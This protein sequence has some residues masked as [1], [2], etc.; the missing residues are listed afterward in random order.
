[1]QK[2]FAIVVRVFDGE[3]P[4]FQ[5]FIDHH[6]SIGVDQF[7]VVLSPGASPLCREILAKN[8]IGFYEAEGQ[9]VGSVWREVKE[10]YVAVVDADEYLHPDLIRFASKEDF[11]SMQMPW[12]MT[13][14]LDDKG[15]LKRR[16]P[17]FVFPQVKSIMR[18]RNLTGLG[19]HVSGTRGDGEKLGLEDGLQFPVHHYYLRGLDDLLLKEGGVVSLTRARS[20]G[21]KPVSL[22]GALGADVSQFPSRHAK[23]AF[24]LNMLK[25]SP[26]VRDPYQLKIDHDML[27]RLHGSAEI[28]L[29]QAKES[30]RQ[31]VESIQQVFSEKTIK[32]QYRNI[33]QMLSEQPRKVSFQKKVLRV[34]RKDFARRQLG[35]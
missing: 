5:S 27:M 12:R 4:Y 30:L 32:R 20:M 29:R 9:R 3:A 15:F 10:D 23:V 17:F 22:S 34:L 1:M 28:D 8:K 7:Y 6:R 33:Q 35:G 16:K 31:S 18:T 2:S 26:V 14:T 13:A 24:V 25:I 11:R 19:L 21:R